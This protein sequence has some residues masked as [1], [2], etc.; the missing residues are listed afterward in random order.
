MNL[1]FFFLF[2]SFLF[3]FSL[4]NTGCPGINSVDQAGVKLRKLPAFV[5]QVLGPKA[6]ATTALWICFSF[7]AV[8][9]VFVFTIASVAHG[10]LQFDSFQKEWFKSPE[11]FWVFCLF[12]CLFAVLL[13]E[14]EKLLFKPPTFRNW[15]EVCNNGGWEIRVTNRKSQ[16]PKKQ[17][18]PRTQVPTGMKLAEIPNIGKRESL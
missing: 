11:N 18:P 10:I 3:F 6:C 16:I 14:K 1:F 7:K 2:F 13:V 12:V 17:G 15:T 4:C 5:S 8:N 9:F